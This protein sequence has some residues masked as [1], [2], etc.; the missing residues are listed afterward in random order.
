MTTVET[1]AHSCA[2]DAALVLAER[3]GVDRHDVAVVLGSGWSGAVDALGDPV[4]ELA[5]T[6]LPGFLAPVADGHAGRI[7]SSLLAGRRVLTFLGRTHLYEGH[8]PEPV[9]HAVRT[10]AAAG[11]RTVVLTSANGSLRAD[12]PAGTGVVLRDHLNLTAVSPLV[13]ASFVDLTD[14]YAPRLRSLAHAADES[15][16]E[17]VYAMLPGPHYETQAEARM[18]RGL[19][20][21]VLGMSTVLEAIAARAAG[22]D[23]LGLSVVTTIEIGGP[24]IDSAEVVAVAAA[25]ATR[26]GATLARIIAELP[27]QPVRAQPAPDPR[28][29]PAGPAER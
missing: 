16:T 26:L 10:A 23:V 7:R 2:T 6:E 21:D 13:G 14:V 3:T 15:L 11:C 17:G 1:G 4:A 27:T 12:W 20:A 5:S 29:V 9:V 22:M 19:G 24:P 25:A 8:G 28:L 18:I